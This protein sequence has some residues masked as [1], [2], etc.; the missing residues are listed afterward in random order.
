[1]SESVIIKERG[2]AG[3]YI[4]G[5]SCRFKRNTLVSYAGQNVVISTVGRCYYDGKYHE[6]GGGRNFETMAFLV[7]E[8]DIRWKDADVKK[9]VSF[10]S[11]W[12]I[13]EFDAEDLA[14]DMHE[15]V[16]AEISDM[17]YNFDC[18]MEY[19]DRRMG[20]LDQA[21]GLMEDAI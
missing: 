13:N 5:D 2:W 6:L 19:R 16:V 21:I 17:V 12:R 3:H 9:Q 10:G 1:M 18:K 14:N 4:L 15:K 7:D 20:F 11:N 8:K